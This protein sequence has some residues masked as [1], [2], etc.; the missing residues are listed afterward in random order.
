MSNYLADIEDWEKT[1]GQDATVTN[2]ECIISQ[3]LPP[4]NTQY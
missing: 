2:A 4:N 3:Q 1:A